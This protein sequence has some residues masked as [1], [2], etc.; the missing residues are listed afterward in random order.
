MQRWYDFKSNMRTNA[1]AKALSPFGGERSQ[2]RREGVFARRYSGPQAVLVIMGQVW[3]LPARTAIP[4]CEY[5]KSK[6][7]LP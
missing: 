2:R 3:A 6:N 1:N 4:E 5:P 7:A